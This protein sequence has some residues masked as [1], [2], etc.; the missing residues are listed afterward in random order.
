MTEYFI[1]PHFNTPFPLA[2]TPPE[3]PVPKVSGFSHMSVRFPELWARCITGWH[4]TRTCWSRV[5]AREICGFYYFLGGTQ[6]NWRRVRL[7]L[8]RSERDG[9]WDHCWLVSWK[10]HLDTFLGYFWDI[11][12]HL[13]ISLKHISALSLVQLYSP[14]SNLIA[15]DYRAY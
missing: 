12:V 4:R 7:S 13:R 9:N 1:A 8:A 6:T 15:I 14:Q 10:F 11:S 5:V 3:F 2:P